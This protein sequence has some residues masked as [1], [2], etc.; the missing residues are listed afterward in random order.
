MSAGNKQAHVKD[1]DKINIAT[2]HRTYITDIYTHMEKLLVYTLNL[3]SY[4]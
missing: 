1:M 3:V 2:H 4:D